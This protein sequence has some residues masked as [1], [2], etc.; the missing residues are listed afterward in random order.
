MKRCKDTPSGMNFAVTAVLVFSAIAILY[1]FSTGI[2]GN[3]FWWHVKVG[4][5]IC[6]NKEIPISDIFSWYGVEKNIP[7]V[8][9]EW[10]SDVIFY[11]IHNLTGDMGIF[12]LSLS[13]AVL[14]T[15]LLWKQAGNYIR[16][17]ILISGLF[18]VLL[19][20]TTK[21]FFYGRPHLFSFFLL[22]IE[23]KLLYAFFDN[24][25]NKGIY[26]I[27]LVSCLWS[28]IHGGSSNLSYLLCL[29]F[30]VVGMLNV[31]IG[32]IT[33]Q[34]LQKQALF[35][36]TIVTVLSVAA[37]LINPVGVEMLL[38]PYKNMGDDLMLTIIGE[39]QAPDAK[40]FGNL[41][42]FFAPVI[43]MLLGFFAEEKKI[44][45][46]DI[47]IMGVFILLF[48]RS[49]RFIMLWY[50]AAAF[51]AFPYVPE[52]KI[53]PISK[54]MEKVLISICILIFVVS[55][56]IVRN[57]LRNTIKENRLITTVLSENAINTVSKDA[58]QRIFNDYNLG[59]TLIYHDL[60]VFFDARADV[61]AYDNLLADGVS[62]LFMEQVNTQSEDIYVDVEALIEKYD[63][64]AFLILKCR[65]L[66]SYLYSHPER[67]ICVF[68]DETV[69]YFKAIDTQNDGKG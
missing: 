10:L 57:N 14:M 19:S 63:F 1:T 6:K 21:V 45:L 35:K 47:G 54:R 4:E 16:K 42:L 50:I 3:D 34:R 13:S 69:G 33:S 9:H 15:S 64:D 46:I 53:K 61:Y 22:F 31:Q 38:Y 32:C 66:C 27:P 30:L 58:P 65:P 12:V 59:E 26:F 8:A 20:V 29:A 51:C 5:W 2:S 36:L 23:M 24:Q 67:F 49:V 55:L 37:I 39:W 60:P 52:C 11:I 56:G 62:L 48:L 40:N 43:F 17:N 25:N 41:I 18:L 7:W 28:N 44:R 68:E